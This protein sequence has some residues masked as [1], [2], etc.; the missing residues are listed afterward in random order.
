MRIVEKNAILENL[1]LF[2]DSW[3]LRE[4]TNGNNFNALAACWEENGTLKSDPDP[5]EASMD[6]TWP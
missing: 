2:V 6:I 3:R 5:N 1:N 4:N